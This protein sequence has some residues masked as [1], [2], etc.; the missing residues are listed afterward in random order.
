[1]KC[2]RFDGAVTEPI[3][4]N[5]VSALGSL[6]APRRIYVNSP[7]GRFLFFTRLGVQ[8]RSKDLTTIA[9]DVASSGAIFFLLGSRRLALP[10]STF[11]FHEAQILPDSSMELPGG[12]F[13]DPST[14]VRTMPGWDI[15]MYQDWEHGRLALQTWLLRFL[16]ESTGIATNIFDN[17]M[18][19]NVTLSP[20]EALEYG[21]AHEV[22]YDE[23]LRAPIPRGLLRI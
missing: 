3:V 17:L 20:R 15:G 1:M 8:L 23:S 6:D 10:D 7:G 18:R 4:Q 12:E 21:I 5:V 11:F 22:I 9:G 19:G 2:I 13:V 14:F 16:H